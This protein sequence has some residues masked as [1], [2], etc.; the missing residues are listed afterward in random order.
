MTAVADAVEQIICHFATAERQSQCEVLGDSSLTPACAQ[1][2]L[3]KLCPA[4]YA[5]LSDG[6]RP[7]LDTAF[8]SIQNSV[9]QVVEA[10]AQQGKFMFTLT[11]Q[12]VTSFY[13][14][15]L[16]EN[17]LIICALGNLHY[18]ISRDPE[19]RGSNPGSGSNFSLEICIVLY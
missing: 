7:T 15:V 10:S 9:W 17:K 6:L 14:I 19:V 13:C 5:I 16:I 1:L 11:P 4:M 3:T 12:V 8:G 18:K 2:A